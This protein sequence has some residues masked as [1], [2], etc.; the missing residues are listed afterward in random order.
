MQNNMKEKADKGVALITTVE[1]YNY[2]ATMSGDEGG[3]T[4]FI[5]SDSGDETDANLYWLR[6][7]GSMLM[8]YLCF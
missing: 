1:A 5:G 6:C 3:E 2:R 7:Y 8:I 4:D